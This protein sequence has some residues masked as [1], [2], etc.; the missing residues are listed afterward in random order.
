MRRRD[1]LIGAT[2]A[3]AAPAIS[4]AQNQRVLKYVP[5]ADAPVLDPI[6]SKSYSVRNHALLVFDT[7]Y[8]VDQNWQPQLQM[9]EGESVEDGSRTWTLTLRE[10][11]RFH[12]GTPVLARDVVA[13]LQR[14]ARRD[15]LGSILMARTDE[16]SAPS[17]RSV[18][19]RLKS[20]LPMFRQ[21]LGKAQPNIPFIMPERLAKTDPATAVTEMVGSGPYRYIASE[22]KP[23]VLSVY[24]RF[25][26][27][28]PRTTGTTSLLAGPKVAHFDRVEWHIIPDASTAAAALQRGEVDWWEQVVADY[29]KPMAGN[30]KLRVEILDR[31]GNYLLIR[32]NFLQPPFNNPKARQAAFAA[33]SQVDVLTAVAGT[34]RDMW[35]SGVGFFHPDSPMNSAVGLD[36]IKEPPDLDH[37]RRLLK[38]SG[39]NGE[40][41]LLIPVANHP[42]AIPTATVVAEAWK[43]VGFNVDLQP[44]ESSALNSKLS[45]KD[46]VDQGGWS[47]FP[48]SPAGIT[49]FDPSDSLY[50]RGH[51]LNAFAGWPDIPEIERLRTAWFE[52]SDTAAQ[53]AIC[54]QLQAICFETLPYIPLG[55]SY[56]ATAYQASLTGMLKVLPL[57]WNV[58][59]T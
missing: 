53:K 26:G 40:R 33:L 37:A 22:R 49:A 50:M 52:A 41:V 38:E 43:K 44:L 2:A 3:L 15:A 57:F 36:R 30:P 17:D 24:E 9:L 54:D 29:A 51:G 25:D 42:R 23:G 5:Y 39:Y 59:R 18:R 58:R 45:R 4:L 34:D 21:V 46:P 56:G 13:S 27:Y 8:G 6:V 31:T 48:D 1:V 20:P 32:C 47:A 28:A 14:W 35:R 55:V 10:G 19:F 12:D 11:L 16:L 7:L